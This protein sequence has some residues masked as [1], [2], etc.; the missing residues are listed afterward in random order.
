M[1]SESRIAVVGV[2]VE[3]RMNAHKKS[4]RSSV[5]MQTLLWDVLVFHIRKKMQE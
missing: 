2:V 4:M 5:F 3:D 1:K